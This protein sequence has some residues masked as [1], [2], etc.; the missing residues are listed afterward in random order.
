MSASRDIGSKPRDINVVARSDI[1]AL[2]RVTLAVDRSSAASL[3]DEELDVDGDADGRRLG[4]STMDHET[5][6]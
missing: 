4:M 1:A 5:T 3:L 2:R 6:S